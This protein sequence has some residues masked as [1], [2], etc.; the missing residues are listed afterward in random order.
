MEPP[1]IPRL[2]AKISSTAEA[3]AEEV[4]I[5]SSGLDLVH[6]KTASPEG[7]HQP[8][9][10]LIHQGLAATEDKDVIDVGGHPHDI[11]LNR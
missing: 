7:A 9:H 10:S 1:N 5:Q 2:D 8:I 3:E 11:L 6:W 4:G